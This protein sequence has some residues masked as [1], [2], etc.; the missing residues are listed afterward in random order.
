MIPREETEG[1]EGEQHGGRGQVTK[2][3]QTLSEGTTAA[4]GAGSWKGLSIFHL[5]GG[6]DQPPQ[7]GFLL[8]TRVTHETLRAEGGCNHTVTSWDPNILGVFFLFFF[9]CFSRAAPVAY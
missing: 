3:I 2:A 5:R 8:T 7:P 1:Q 4:A 9:F 6:E